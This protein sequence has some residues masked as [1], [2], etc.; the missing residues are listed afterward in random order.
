MNKNA[1]GI[2]EIII[3]KKFLRRNLPLAK[4]KSCFFPLIFKATRNVKSSAQRITTKL[5]HESC[6][7]QRIAKRRGPW[8]RLAGRVRIWYTATVSANPF[9]IFFPSFSRKS[10]L[11]FTTSPFFLPLKFIP[12]SYF[13]WS[14]ACSTSSWFNLE[15]YFLLSDFPWKRIVTNLRNLQDKQIRGWEL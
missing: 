12:S 1:L 3:I 6:G 9:L 13:N 2:F 10:F 4:R 11:S 7:L 15:C 8:K 5:I 14:C